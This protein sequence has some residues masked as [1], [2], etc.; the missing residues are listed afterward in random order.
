MASPIRILL[1]EDH[2]L[3]AE[4]VGHEL[5]KSGFDFTLERAVV[6]EDFSRKLT[7]FSPDLIISDYYLPNFTGLTALHVARQ[8]N[9]LV[10]FLIITGSINEE[11]AVECMKAGA[12]DYILKAHLS[13]T[14]LARL[15]TAIRNALETR[16][17]REEK[18]QAEEALRRSEAQMRAILESALDC[19]ITM[20]HEGR[21]IEFNA[22]SEKTFGF[23]RDQVLGRSMADLIVPPALRER[24]WRGLANY[25]ASGHGPI[26]DKRIEMTAMRQNGDEF[27]V[28]LTVTHINS[29]GPPVFTGFIR[30]ISERKRAEDE[31][32]KL[33]REL[34]DALGKVKTLS[35]LLPICASCKKVRDDKGY[36]HQVESYLMSRADVSITHG[37]CPDCAARLYPDVFKKDE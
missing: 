11:T 20:D 3:D 37:F 13:R 16:K 31:R 2:P 15:N 8:W 26:L 24:H 28:E 4:L 17:F 30:D 1:L 9:P 22:A 21:I 33:I 10:P 14:N 25:L 19:I 27:P 36:W 7:E 12:N 32:E 34:Q 5:S 6:A 18:E 23:T 29:E 35:G